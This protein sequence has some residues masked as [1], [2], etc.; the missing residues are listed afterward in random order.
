MTNLLPTSSP[1]PFTAV[2]CGV[3][4]MF[5]SHTG[6]SNLVKVA[7][8]IKFLGNDLQP[9]K[10]QYTEGDLPELTIYPPSI[11][12]H[13]EANTTR[14]QYVMRFQL[15]ISTGNKRLDT[16]TGQPSIYP[17]LW[18]IFRAMLLWKTSLMTLTYGSAAFVHLAKPGKAEISMTY[19]DQNKTIIGWSAKLDYEVH[20]NFVSSNIA[21]TISL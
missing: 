7:N 12:P 1:D 10:D 14:S 2:Y 19:H 21:P 9:Q 3:W 13:L 4:D 5:E 17:V 15:L 20:L 8:R 11:E 6:F 18:E 16:L